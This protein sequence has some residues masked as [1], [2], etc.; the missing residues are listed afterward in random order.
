[1][2]TLYDVLGVERNA[3][4]EEIKKAFKQR[5]IWYHPD[6]NPNNPHAEEQFKLLNQAYQILMDSLKRQQYD[7]LLAYEEFH[8]Q[9]RQRKYQASEAAYQNQSSSSEAVGKGGEMVWYKKL[10]FALSFFGFALVVMV[11]LYFFAGFDD[12]DKQNEVYG[13]IHVKLDPADS[14][15]EFYVKNSDVAAVQKFVRSGKLE[16]VSN[17]SKYKLAHFL[18]VTSQDFIYEKNYV[19]SFRT[20]TTVYDYELKSYLPVSAYE[21]SK[22]M[23]DLLFRLNKDSLAIVFMRKNSYSFYEK[24]E[25]ENTIANNFFNKQK[26]RYAYVYYQSASIAFDAYMKD[27]FGD[28]YY[29]VSSG[30]KLPPLYYEFLCKKGLTCVCLDLDQEAFIVLKNAQSMFPDQ[31]K[32]YL[33]LADLYISRGENRKGCQELEEAFLNCKD[34]EGL[35]PTI[36]KNCRNGRNN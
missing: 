8:R 26:Y 36:L 17:D 7:Q 15:V 32:A 9:E 14:L 16:G 2:S 22:F 13:S 34:I 18:Y 24:F 28:A 6:K 21:G 25:T 23:G 5:A 27:K 19:E 29:M 31:S 35:T 11:A 4:Y 1:M 12:I 30:V 33:I 10:F 3:S 20:M